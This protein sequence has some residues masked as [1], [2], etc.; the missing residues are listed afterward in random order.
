[1][2][3]FTLDTNCLIDIADNRADAGS[4][5]T[6]A[7]A[8]A[9]G[10]ANVAVVAVSASETQEN[11][12]RLTNFN[13]FQTLLDTLALSHLE[14]LKPILYWD[15]AFWDWAYW[16]EPTMVDL[17]RLIHG[18]LF[19]NIEFLWP[20]YCHTRGWDPNT[21]PVNAKWRNAKCDVL[22]LW[23][24]IHHRRNVFVTGDRNFHAATKLNNL[25]ALGAGRIEHPKAATALLT[26]TAHAV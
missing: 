12:A 19:P 18:V 24:H 15:I 1:M 21:Q 14:I 11:G 3:T 16:A 8:H 13:E 6:L 9:R 7:D 20:D 17:E 23:S 26:Q 4:V 5:Q 10:E 2:L 22:A 25:I